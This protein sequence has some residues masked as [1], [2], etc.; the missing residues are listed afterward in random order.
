[1]AMAATLP[2]L[3]P[4][5]LLAMALVLYKLVARYVAFPD[6]VNTSLQIRLHHG[7][8]EK[9]LADCHSCGRG[10]IGRFSWFPVLLV[11]RHH[12]VEAANT[13]EGRSLAEEAPRR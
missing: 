2:Y 6:R 12:H 7:F 13:S 8:G 9:S 11:S 4:G 1:M 3:I 5:S 10:S